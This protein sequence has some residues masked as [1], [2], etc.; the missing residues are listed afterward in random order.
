MPATAD[1][2]APWSPIPPRWNGGE[3]PGVVSIEAIPE[4]DQKAPMS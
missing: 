4:R 2:P 1:T 3:L